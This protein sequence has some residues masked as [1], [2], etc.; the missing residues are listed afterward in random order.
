MRRS[1]K[2]RTCEQQ[3]RTALASPPIVRQ[4]RRLI[5]Q[6]Q[7]LTDLSVVRPS[8]LI[9]TTV[10]STITASGLTERHNA[11][12]PAPQSIFAFAN[13]GRYPLGCA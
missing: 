13:D 5:G 7:P 3:N 10:M 12:T 8:D 1:M 6:F 11:N 2:T 4:K 9:S